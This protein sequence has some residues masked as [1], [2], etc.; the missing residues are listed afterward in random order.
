MSYEFLIV[1]LCGSV[2][3]MGAL[4]H[5]KYGSHDKEVYKWDKERK[6]LNK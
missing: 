5:L 4:N 6:K 3:I 1:L 2:I